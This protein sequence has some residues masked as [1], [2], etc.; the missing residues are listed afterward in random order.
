MG[1]SR[2]EHPVGSVASASVASVISAGDKWDG[3]TLSPG[4]VVEAQIEEGVWARARVVKVMQNGSRARVQYF[5]CEPPTS[6]RVVRA[7]AGD[8]SSSSSSSYPHS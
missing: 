2:F 6:G 3:G 1:E 7:E 5:D 4:Q 8:N